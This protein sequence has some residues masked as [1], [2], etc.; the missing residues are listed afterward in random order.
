[1]NLT[2]ETLK[3]V[4]RYNT[5]TGI[6]TWRISPSRA[7]KKGVVAGSIHPNTGHIFISIQ[8]KLY[9]AH[10]LAWLYVY[11][12]WPS[13]SVDHIDG[14][15]ANNQIRNLRELTHT[16]NLQAARKARR[17]NRSGLLG[18]SFRKDCNK[19]QAR[20][21]RNKKPQSLGFFATAEE[22]HKAYIAHK[23]KN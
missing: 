2:Q 13:L 15:P 14:N 7:V 6:F 5:K 8:R 12:A 1:M 20:I 3:E 4:L 11:G 9:A 18:V 19:W 10:R 22:A 23:L 16:Q 17:D 21:Q